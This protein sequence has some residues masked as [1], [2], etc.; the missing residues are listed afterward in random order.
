MYGRKP[1]AKKRKVER[2]ADSQR[3]VNSFGLV[4]SKSLPQHLELLVLSFLE[5]HELYELPEVSKDVGKLTTAY[6]S[7]VREWTFATLPAT[8]PRVLRSCRQLQSLCIQYAYNDQEPLEDVA[9]MIR[10]NAETLRRFECTSAALQRYRA[11]RVSR[12]AFPDARVQPRDAPAVACGPR[13]FRSDLPFLA[14]LAGKLPALLELDFRFNREQAEAL[15]ELLPPE[16]ARAKGACLS[17]S[18]SSGSE[19][20]NSRTRRSTSSC[21]IVRAAGGARYWR[22]AVRGALAGR[23]AA[24]WPCANREEGGR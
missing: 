16:K 9:A 1:R 18:C 12:L 24:E 19:Q 15:R 4:A 7:Q 6:F 10:D 11:S 3:P 5:P 13:G 22:G 23:V 20:C 17:T 8:V 14:W 2:E 21:S